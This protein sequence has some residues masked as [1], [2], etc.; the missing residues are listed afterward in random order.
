M[1][2][3]HVI[4]REILYKLLFSASL[5]HS[6]LIAYNVTNSQFKFHIDELI[7]E[8]LVQKLEKNYSLTEK[9]KEWANRINAKDL[10]FIKQPKISVMLCAISDQKVLIQTRAKNP[11]L[12][13]QSF[14]TKKVMYGE[15]TFNAAHRGLFEETGLKGKPILFGLRHFTVLN[16]DRTLL[17]DQYLYLYKFLNPEGQL[18]ENNEG[19]LMWADQNKIKEHVT[20]VVNGFWS[21]LD[22]LITNKDSLEYIE[23]EQIT[24]NY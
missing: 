9:G 6:D 16:K 4:Q 8:N 5:R 1:R 3:M 11:F 17:E 24:A 18:N 12:G 15:T 23:E 20:K 19:Y 22:V 13:C 21:V 14:P 7:K 2:L 10:S